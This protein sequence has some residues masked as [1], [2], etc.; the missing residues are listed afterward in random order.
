MNYPVTFGTFHIVFYSILKQ[1]YG[2]NSH[3]LLSEQESLIILK[4]SLNQTYIESYV[5][6]EDEEELLRDISQEIGVVKNG[7]YRLDE[8]HSQNLNTD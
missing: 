5:Q 6:V 3:H 4:E 1:E 8:F 7:L 2:I